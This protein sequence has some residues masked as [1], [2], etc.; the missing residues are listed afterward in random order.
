MN[1]YPI[2]ANQQLRPSE[3]VQ[4]TLISTT[5]RMT[6]EYENRGILITHAWPQLQS[7]SI[8]MRL[9]ETH[10]SRS[11][12][13]I[14]FETPPIEKAP[15]VP[16]PDYSPTGEIL[17]A[18]LSVLFGK[19]FDCH[20]LFEGSGFYQIPDL[21]SYDTP[22]NP[23]L[24]F[25]SHDTRQCYEVPLEINNF[26]MIERVFIG[27]SASIAE[28]SRL[29]AACKFYMQ[30]LQNAEHNSEVAYL[31]LITAGEI[32]SGEIRCADTKGVKGKFVK[33]LYSLLDDD[34]YTASDSARSPVRFGPNNI[35]RSIG[36]AYDLRSCY[37]HT[38]AP[39][40]MWVDPTMGFASGDLP[41][42]K[43]V[44]DDGNL[45]RVL[46]VAPTF[47]GL[48]RLVRYCVLRLMASRGLLVRDANG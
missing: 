38:G 43:P 40:G 42:G 4:K 31:H 37:V 6:G 3:T 8:S 27:P 34:F 22:C 1:N 36:A 13:V 24:P 21:G 35:E 7:S 11:G 10:M 5:S 29:N 28:L 12:Y 30:A 18:Y 47:A 44:V 48:E 20:G 33:A 17:A 23:K 39:F 32:L 2:K 14:A 15:G 26:A 46:A 16:V 25:N 9:G 41:I 19:R 45:G